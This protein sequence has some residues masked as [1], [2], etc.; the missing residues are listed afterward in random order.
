MANPTQ[1]ALVFD[2]ATTD[3]PL[4][5]LM[6][7]KANVNPNSADYDSR[8]ALHVAAATGNLRAVQG[9]LYAGANLNAQDRCEWTLL[10]ASFQGARTQCSTQY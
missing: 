6:C 4:L 10:P 8:S 3:W 1:F 2:A 9:L 7:G 5:T